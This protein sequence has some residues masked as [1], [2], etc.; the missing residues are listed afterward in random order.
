MTEKCS[1]RAGPRGP[2]SPPDGTSWSWSIYNLAVLKSVH[3]QPLKA[4]LLDFSTHFLASGRGEPSWIL[5]YY[6]YY[7]RFPAA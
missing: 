6:V 1:F 5:K 4:R 7:L 2:L 3:T